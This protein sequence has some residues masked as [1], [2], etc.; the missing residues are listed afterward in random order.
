MVNYYMN[1][2]TGSFD[3]WLPPDNWVFRFEGKNGANICCKKQFDKTQEQEYEILMIDGSK[4]EKEL[5]ILKLENMDKVSM[6]QI[7]NAFNK[8]ALLHHPDHIDY[9]T[10]EEEKIAN[11][12]FREINQAFISLKSHFELMEKRKRYK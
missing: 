3:E 9:Q 11:D 6:Q 12:K 4:F 7:R 1:Y 5:K 8:Q 10:E 2:H